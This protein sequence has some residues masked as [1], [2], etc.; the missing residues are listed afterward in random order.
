MMLI[1]GKRSL[2][3]LMTLLLTLQ[4]V[5]ADVT[6]NSTNFPDDNFRTFLTK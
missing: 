4:D 3:L 2:F 1:G 5:T 6:I